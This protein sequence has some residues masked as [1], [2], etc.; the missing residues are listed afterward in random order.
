M[1]ILATVKG[2]RINTRIRKLNDSLG[3]WD[4]VHV[5]T[6]RAEFHRQWVETILHQ[7]PRYPEDVENQNA[8]R[9]VK[10][11]DAVRD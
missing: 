4:V 10:C 8:L 2:A 3:W 9:D 7:F 1:Y 11:K 6:R 5:G